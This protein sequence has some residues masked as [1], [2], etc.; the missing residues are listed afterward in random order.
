MRLRL[1]ID[2]NTFLWIKKDRG[3]MYNSS[4]FKSFEFLVSDSIIN[5][6]ESLQVLG[7]LYQIPLD[8][9]YESD[10]V[11]KHWI[12]KIIHIGSAKI[13]S[14]EENY[15]P[16]LK[17][18][19]RVQHDIEKIVKSR[20][21]AEVVNSLKEIN[22][23]LNGVDI[24]EKEEEYHKQ[25]AYPVKSIDE[26]DIEN[27]SLFL[28]CVPQRN[29]IKLNFVGDYVSY[30]QLS[31]LI[32]EL[33]H[34]INSITFYFRIEDIYNWWRSIQSFINTYN[35]H[36]ICKCTDELP[37]YVEFVKH[38]VIHHSFSFL[39]TSGMDL[40]LIDSIDKTGLE[41]TINPLFTGVN[42]AFFEE[43]IYIDMADCTECTVDKRHIFMNQTLN[44][45]FF[46]KLDILP[47][48]SIWDNLNFS[49]I[50]FTTDDFFEMLLSVFDL[51]RSWFYIRNQSPC[52]HCLYQWLC[53]PPSNYEIVMDKCNL[54]HIIS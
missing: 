54:C 4:N 29:N 10:P 33:S 44:G 40:D 18:V 16:S 24:H 39:A 14:F 36:L 53:P 20:N 30:T 3:L 51:S 7:N 25:F 46:G 45:N 8:E 38:N 28:K 9:S 6:C 41:Y 49:K 12:D 17:P 22:I 19:L 11:L 26:L 5:I 48:G 23:H 47:D 21:F 35:I 43:Y 50:G 13:E 15:T 34:R 27:L 31:G 1:I 32:E 37:I 52:A 42:K 2:K